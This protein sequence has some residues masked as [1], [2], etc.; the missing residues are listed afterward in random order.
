[1]LRTLASRPA[2]QLPP[3]AAEAI[4]SAPATQVGGRAAIEAHF[5]YK[6]VAP[7]PVITQEQRALINAE[8][9]AHLPQWET[10]KKLAPGAHEQTKMCV[11][12]D[13]Y[14]VRCLNGH[15]QEYKIVY[16][17]PTSHYSGFS[18][19]W[20][21]CSFMCIEVN[22]GIDKKRTDDKFASA[23]A[24]LCAQGFVWN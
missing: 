20:M 17:A 19:R 18:L 16:T 6:P 4:N 23:I 9:K 8:I 12:S 5:G 2:V 21:T 14:Q 7:T 3:D 22:Y 1:M 10:F 11:L 15:V 24:N 13:T